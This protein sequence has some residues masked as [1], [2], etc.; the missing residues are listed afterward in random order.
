MSLIDI[1]SPNLQHMH[2]TQQRPNE[3]HYR[4]ILKISLIFLFKLKY[5]NII[6]SWRH[7]FFSH[8]SFHL[9]LA[10]K[11]SQF[12][13]PYFSSVISSFDTYY[14][15]CGSDFYNHPSTALDNLLCFSY[16]NPNSFSRL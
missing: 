13:L 10:T 2:K 6:K 15:R 1:K 9:Q 3:I 5:K 14:V 12:H 11:S 4:S 16:P 8:P 7:N